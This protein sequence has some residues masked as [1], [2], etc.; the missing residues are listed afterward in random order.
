MKTNAIVLTI[1][2]TSA[3]AAGPAAAEGGQYDTY[4]KT[5]QS[6]F[7]AYARVVSVEPVTTSVRVDTPRRECWDETVTHYGNSG[8]RR[9]SHTSML[10]G[11]LLGGVVGNQF[12]KGSG[13]TLMTVAGALLGGSIGNDH[14][15]NRPAYRQGYTTT[16]QRCSVTYEQH[17][18]ERIQ[19][20]RVEYV[21]DGQHYSTHMDQPPGD[22]I[23]VNVSVTPAS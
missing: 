13:N 8:Y 20:Y 2:L 6:G 19:G 5:Y 10:L 21:Y 1:A 4:E 18:E 17:Y 23:R 22:R 9:N 11:G 15:R 3:L 14:Q 16:E 12:G 7:T